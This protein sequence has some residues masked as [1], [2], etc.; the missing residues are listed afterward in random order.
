MAIGYGTFTGFFENCISESEFSNKTAATKDNHIYN[1]NRPMA[2]QLD[3]KISTKY[4]Y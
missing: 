3:N 1:Y 4:R 2:K